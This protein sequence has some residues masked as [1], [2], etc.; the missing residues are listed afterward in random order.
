[1]STQNTFVQKTT[2]LN[3]VK[4]TRYS[5]LKFSYLLWYKLDIKKFN[6]LQNIHMVICF[7]VLFPIGT[8]FIE[9]N[10]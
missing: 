10:L 6:L 2:Y 9:D 1:M 5:F 7:N 8:L 4:L 3:I